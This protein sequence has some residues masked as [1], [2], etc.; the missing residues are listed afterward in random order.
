MSKGFRGDS[1]SRC[2]FCF[3][4]G[5]ATCY[6]P[7]GV[8]SNSHPFQLAGRGLPRGSC[9]FIVTCHLDGG[10]VSHHCTNVV[11]AMGGFYPTHCPTHGSP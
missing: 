10:V 4:G 8:F 5:C 11:L 6:V 9:M 1:F 3:R 7:R 2:F